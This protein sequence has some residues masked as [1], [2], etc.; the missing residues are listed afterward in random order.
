MADTHSPA[1]TGVSPLEGH[2]GPDYRNQ[3]INWYNSLW[4]SFDRKPPANLLAYAVKHRLNETEFANLVR[5]K[6]PK[7]ENSPV[8]LEQRQAAVTMLNQAFNGQSWRKDKKIMELVKRFGV[9]ANAQKLGQALAAMFKQVVAKNP[10]FVAD[11]PGWSAWWTKNKDNQTDA[12]DPASWIVK[13]NDDVDTAKESFQTQYAE[14]MGVGAKMPDEFFWTAF[15]AGW[16]PRGVD[17]NNAIRGEEGWETSAG[18]TS[19]KEE[20]SRQWDIIFSD[21]KGGVVR[22]LDDAL[23]SA[24]A[25]SGMPFDA[26]FHSKIKSQSWFNDAFPDYAQWETDTSRKEGRSAD[27]LDIFSYFQDK[28]DTEKDKLEYVNDYRETFG[29]DAVPDQAIIDRAIKEKWSVAVFH[30]YVMKNDPKRT[31]TQEY[32]DKAESFDLYYKDIFGENSVPD[33]GLRDE[34]VASG[35]SDTKSMW[36]SIK[37]TSAFKSQYANWD[38]YSSAQEAQGNMVSNNPQQYKEYQAGMEAAFARIGMPVPG[39]MVKQIFASGVDMGE[40]GSN[41]EAY[42]DTKTSYDWQTGQQA[43]LATAAGVENKPAGGDLRKRMEAALAQHQKYAGSKF[44]E[45][46]TD[47][48]TGT[49]KI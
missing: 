22:P 8:A 47:T 43:D 1:E 10:K 14:D 48:R 26:F 28:A 27:E 16:E 11:H 31:E 12:Y 49:K 45:F 44:N 46:D 7:W 20:F 19:K 17:W 32:K 15:N 40:M 25:K 9:I 33:A 21:G 6:D 39:G 34:F 38:V 36:D 2:A 5:L 35:S 30:N 29:A 18:A 13:Y 4:K 24:Y 41:L 23:A 42:S 37:G 3:V